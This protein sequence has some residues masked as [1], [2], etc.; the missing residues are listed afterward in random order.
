[1][2]QI[3][4]KRLTIL[5]ALLYLFYVMLT[6]VK[7]KAEE[8]YGQI[9]EQFTDYSNV[10]GTT[11]V[12]L[13]LGAPEG[14]VNLSKISGVV[15]FS[16]TYKKAC[17]IASTQ[18]GLYTA[19]GIVNLPPQNGIFPIVPEG[20]WRHLSK[21]KAYSQLNFAGFLMSSESCFADSDTEFAPISFGAESSILTI[22]VNSR[23]ALRVHASITDTD[24]D[25][26]SASCLQAPPIRSVAFDTICTLDLV[27]VQAPQRGRLKI[28][29]IPR[30]GPPLNEFYHVTLFPQG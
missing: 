19:E 9:Q 28:E 4:N 18:D 16:N 6:A 25:T 21:V 20:A 23:R 1:M 3:K 17:Y 22:S 11:L 13:Q 5:A 27:K 24:G 30:I 14:K 12:G 26:V 10:S 29:I 8:I 15:G 7:P 2:Q